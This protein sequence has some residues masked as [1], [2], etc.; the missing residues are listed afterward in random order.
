MSI[1]M[2]I[3]FITIIIFSLGL[4]SCSSFLHE[5][6][7]K[8]DKEIANERFQRIIEALENK[9]KE[10]LKKMF[11]PNALD[12]VQD[13]DNDIDY[14]MEFYKGKLESKDDDPAVVRSDS[15]DY[16]QKKSE[17]DCMYIF[18]TDEDT[19]LMFFI[20]KIVDNKNIDNV[21]LY[22]LQIINE[23]DKKEEFEGGGSEMMHAGIYR[24]DADKK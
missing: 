17:L 21:G 15:K 19:Y 2:I 10:A 18:T 23:S 13:I 22:R 12:K 8:S 16:G 7:V 14:M 24:P 1:K 6:D 3:L 9:D 5:R 4:L 20:D 11:S